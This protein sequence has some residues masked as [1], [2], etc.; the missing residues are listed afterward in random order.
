MKISVIIPVYNERAT[1]REILRKVQAVQLEKE[2]LIIDD[3]S[4]DGTRAI[5]ADLADA[6]VRVFL[7]PANQG[8]GAAVRT[9]LAHVTGEL[10]I[11]QDADLE[12]DP[13]DYPRLVEPIATGTADVVYGSRFLARGRRATAFW[14]YAG[15]RLLTLISNLFTGLH[16]TDMET[17]YKAFRVDL[18]RKMHLVSNGFDIEPELTA[19]AARMGARIREVPI[20]YQGRGYTE[21][22]K[23]GWRDA[24][25]TLRAIVRFGL[26][27]RD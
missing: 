12:Y 21:G 3:G 10:V 17:C 20:A 15:N 27:E 25:R 1:I 9:G 18:I 7:H 2:I 8:K 26:F 11:I 19:K 14:H 16:L 13:S 23:I 5:L 4:H 22:K 6:N 24:L